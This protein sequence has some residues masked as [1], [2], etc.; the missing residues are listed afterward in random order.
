MKKLSKIALKNQGSVLNEDEM[1]KILGGGSYACRC[2]GKCEWSPEE[3]SGCY[4]TYLPDGTPYTG[5]C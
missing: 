3:I 1:Q 5:S 2:N 4:C